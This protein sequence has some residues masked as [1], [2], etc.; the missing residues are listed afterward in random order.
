MDTKEALGDAYTR[1]AP[2]YDHTA[3][4]IYLKA[5]WTLMPFVEVTKQ[6]AVLDVGCGTGINLLE[7]A[8]AL[9]PCRSLVGVDLSPGM[10]EI[11]R[12]K[13]AAAGLEATFSVGD[14]ES[15]ELPDASFDLVVC[16]SVYHWFPDRA[17]AISEL[18]RVLRPG[19]QLLLATLAFPGY[20][21]WIELVD[22]AWKKL[23]GRTSEALPDMPTPFELTILLRAS[24]LE[25]DHFKYQIGPSL[26][27]DVRGFLTTM[28]VIAPVWFAGAP[29]GDG[30]RVM[31]EL[32]RTIETRWPGG[33]TCTQA[34]IEVVARK[35][36]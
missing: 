34:G 36:R 31:A 12:R 19:G 10:L 15:L 17:R 2:A 9:G 7:I 21:E 26:I 25:L 1:A 18:A 23:Y 35:R 22:A 33:F 30:A 11:A 28:A 6:P 5:L 20:E 32:T 16:N 3:G 13:A 14:A 29:D 24:G 8:R 27:R 4:G